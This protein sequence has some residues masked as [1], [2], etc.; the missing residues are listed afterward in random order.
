MK[1]TL[2]VLCLFG[3]T[4]A[5]GQAVGV[6]S[7]LSSQPVI[8][9]FVSHPEHAG[10][11]AM[12]QEQNLREQAGYVYAQGERPLWD[13]VRASRALPLGDAARVL[14]KEHASAKKAQIVWEN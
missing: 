8:T 10:S 1:T 4:T 11:H 7:A 2:F 9:E 13:V 14:R 12:G 3:A 5:F 6:G